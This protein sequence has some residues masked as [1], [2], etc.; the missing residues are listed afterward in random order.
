[1]LVSYR[2]VPKGKN[3]TGSL[4]EISHPSFPPTD[5]ASADTPKPSSM[6][7]VPASAARRGTINEENDTDP[8]EAEMPEVMLDRNRHIVPEWV[9]RENRNRSLS[10]SSITG[11]SRRQLQRGYLDRDAA[12]SP[13]LASSTPVN[14]PQVK[15]S[16]LSRYPFGSSQSDAPTPVNSPSQNGRAFPSHFSLK[17]VSNGQHT[18]Y[19]SDDDEHFHRPALRAF[20]SEKAF[21]LPQSPWFGGT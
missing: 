11:S 16:P 3:G 10:Y 13:E 8:D 17:S 4:K 7:P 5:R 6:I 18:K 2:R 9:L 19:I 1:M 12:S 21:G 20:N 15:P 14:V